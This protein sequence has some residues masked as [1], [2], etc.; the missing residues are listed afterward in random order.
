MIT[1]ALKHL[2]PFLPQY[3]RRRANVTFHIELIP[4][5]PL[6]FYNWNPF[7]S[8]SPSQDSPLRQDFLFFPLQVQTPFCTRRTL[9]LFSPPLFLFGTFDASSLILP[10]PVLRSSCPTPLL[11]PLG[12]SDLKY[13]GISFRQFSPSFPP[14]VLGFAASFLALW[15]LPDSP[16]GKPVNQ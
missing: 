5:V 1:C 3:L 11:Q 8:F 2:V 6:F 7:C 15:V 13:E 9:A 12:I 16:S 4:S 14:F 10:F